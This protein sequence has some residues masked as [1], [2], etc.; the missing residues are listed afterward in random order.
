MDG[1]A[2]VDVDEII[3]RHALRLHCSGRTPEVPST[4]LPS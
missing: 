3:G 4:G 2:R 1:A